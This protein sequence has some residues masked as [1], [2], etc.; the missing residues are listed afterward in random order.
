MPERS[1]SS[2]VP[3]FGEKQE[4]M[5]ILG[6]GLE[7]NRDARPISTHIEVLSMHVNLLPERVSW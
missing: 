6:M 5:E 2:R 1:L 4:E 7:V 3:L